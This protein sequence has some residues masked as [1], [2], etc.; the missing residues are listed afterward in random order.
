MEGGLVART[1][2]NSA[3][4]RSAMRHVPAAV[5]LIA[6]GTTGA[7]TGLTATA[8]CPL[9]DEPPAMLVCVNRSAGAHD[10][11]VSAGVFSMNMLAA[12]QEQIGE[13]FAGRF[14]QRGEERFAGLTWRTLVTGA[15]VFADA[16]CA[17]DCEVIEAR[18]LA[19]HSVIVGRVVG[20]VARADA[21]PLLYRDGRY[22]TLS[23]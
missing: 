14:G 20:G 9:S 4:F 7:R 22:V 10:V 18:P 3:E 5:W 21:L 6:A 19:T 12:G 2:M 15:P 1:E 16:L 13:R 23:R 8:V 17:L 11:I